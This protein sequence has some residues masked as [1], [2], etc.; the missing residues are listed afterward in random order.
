MTDKPCYAAPVSI[1]QIPR[2]QAV[3]SIVPILTE[4]LAKGGVSKHPWTTANAAS[5]GT[6]DS[7]GCAQWVDRR[8]ANRRN[9]PVEPDT[10][11]AFQRHNQGER[12]AAR[13]T[14]TYV[15][16]AS[17]RQHMVFESAAAHMQAFQKMLGG[18]AGDFNNIIGAVLGNVELARA[19]LPANSAAAISLS[20]ID[21]AG[22]RARDLV[23]QMLSFNPNEPASH[24]PQ[25]PSDLV[26][27]AGV[28]AEPTVKPVCHTG[29]ATGQRVMYVDDDEAL[30]FLVKRV[31]SR[32]G[33]AVETFT[34]PRQALAALRA[35]PMAFDLLVTDYNMPHYSGLELVRD[36]QTLR[37]DL[38][39]A[40]ASGYLTPEVENAALLAGARALIHKPDDVNEWCNTVQQLLG[41]R[42]DTALPHR[43]SMA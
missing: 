12:R 1:T 40:L 42:T 39:L 14:D 18:L 3:Q 8:R 17:L 25:P 38:P 21:K 4:G 31:L 15:N 36:A 7:V 37:P 43:T 6:A 27:T 41:L 34:D 28:Q 2:L 32:Q 29:Q 30:V 9:N 20:E 24:T 22:R 13:V 35:N 33:F 10:G 26:L 5:Q 11:L 19:E 16:Q 23:R